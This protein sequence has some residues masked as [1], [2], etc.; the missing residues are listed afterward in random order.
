M[1]TFFAIL[2]ANDAYLASH[3]PGF[4]KTVLDI[5][6]NLFVRV[7]L[8]TNVQKTQT[9]I[10]TPGPG[11]IRIQLPKDSYARMCGGMILAKGVGQSDGCMLPM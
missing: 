7:G 8:K 1:A 4:L 5:L 6:V 9:M 3:D 11:R 2:Y 10:C